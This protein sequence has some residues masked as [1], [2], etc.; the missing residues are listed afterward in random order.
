MIFPLSDEKVSYKRFI[1]FCVIFLILANVIIFL[2]MLS[3]PKEYI[4]KYALFPQDI[5]EGKNFFS[6]ISSMFLHGTFLHLIFNMWFLWIFGDNLEWRLGKIRFILFYFICGIIGGLFFA[7][8]SSK[9]IPAVGASG[10]ISGILGGY[11]VLFPKNK[12]KI[13]YP[14]FFPP[15]LIPAY[16]PAFV[17]L[18]IWFLYQIF[19]PEPYVASSAHIFGFLAGAFLAKIFKKR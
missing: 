2:M 15:F 18:L 8:L 9:N 3:C 16:I 11:F 7:I 14:V 5:K 6:L 19:Y 4:Q 13:L 12:I 10:A 1:P 17:F